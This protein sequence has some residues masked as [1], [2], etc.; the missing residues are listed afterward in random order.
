MPAPWLARCCAL[1]AQEI[2]SG[3]E[4]SSRY[5]NQRCGRLRPRGLA[6]IRIPRTCLHGIGER[7]CRFSLRSAF[8][9]AR[10]IVQ[11]MRRA[12]ID[13]LGSTCSARHSRLWLI[14]LV[15]HALRDS[16]VT[17]SRRPRSIV[18]LI[19]GIVSP[20]WTRPGSFHNES[21]RSRCSRRARSSAGIWAQASTCRSP[22]L[23]CDGRGLK[24]GHIDLGR[25]LLPELAG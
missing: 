6:R 12:A 14:E 21:A 4:S 10:Q 3:H 25:R 7:R 11:H 13:C 5:D 8:D 2:G 22:L 20:S 16:V 15:G 24:R 19:V 1:L 17:W 23:R 9:V 18:K